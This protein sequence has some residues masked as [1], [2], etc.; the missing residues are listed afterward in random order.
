MAKIEEFTILP[1]VRKIFES[2]EKEADDW[3]R[4]HLGGS[5][6]GTEC[7]RALWYAFRW[8]TPPKMD[9]RVRRLLDTGKREEERLLSELRRIGIVIEGEQF[10]FQDV[11]GHFGG[12]FDAVGKGFEESDKW[13][14]L[15]F[16]T[17]N[18]KSFKEI[19]KKGVKEAKPLHYAQMQVYML[20]ESFER[21]YYFVVNKNTDE[22][23]G[24]RVPFD[25][26]FAEGLIQKARTIIFSAVPL[27]RISDDPE[28]FLCRFCT[29]RP[30]CHQKAY[31]EVHCRT[32]LHATPEPKGEGVWTCE[33]RHVPLSIEEQKAG[34]DRHLYIPNLVPFP[35]IDASM[36]E[37]S[38]T[39]EGA[40][41]GGPDGKPSKDLRCHF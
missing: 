36:A 23:H 1:T 18:D 21:A 27:D 9:G 2:Y 17:S 22:I 5:L 8:A 20:A 39:Y 14:L 19:Q 15:E 3:R 32:C 12:S 28:S 37:N 29:Y 30:A 40:K 7:M 38:V 16:K 35:L 26:T 31:S 4:P 24:E 33:D 25:R 13:H 41:N 6:I 10:S 34:C 11:S